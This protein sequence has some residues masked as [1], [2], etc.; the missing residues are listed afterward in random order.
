MSALQSESSVCLLQVG[1]C[2]KCPTNV[3]SSTLQ[4]YS[5]FDKK[6]DDKDHEKFYDDCVKIAF[7]ATHL[8]DD[9]QCDASSTNYKLFEAMLGGY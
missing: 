6:E 5:D 1:Y 2:I 9:Y 7:N 8:K 4:G 3:F